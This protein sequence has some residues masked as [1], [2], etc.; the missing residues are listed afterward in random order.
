MTHLDWWG[1]MMANHSTWN[2]CFKPKIQHPMQ[3]A[4]ICCI[5]ILHLSFSGIR[6][7]QSLG[8]CVCF[9]DRCLSFFIW[10]L[11][12][13]FF[14]DLRILITSL[15]SSNTS[16]YHLLVLTSQNDNTLLSK[17]LP[18]LLKNISKF[19]TGE[20]NNVKKIISGSIMIECFKH[21]VS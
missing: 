9:I 12:C 13:L 21:T 10:L 4:N 5:R 2:L 20:V 18:F 15:V 17:I 11:C 19:A 1:T 8:L 14:F 7:T 6:V 16:W 3:K